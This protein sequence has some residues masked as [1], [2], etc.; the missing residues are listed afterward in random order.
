[1]WGLAIC[2]VLG[3]GDDAGGGKGVGVGGEVFNTLT[4]FDFR[5]VV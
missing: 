4:D 5:E 1:M 3:L 2:L